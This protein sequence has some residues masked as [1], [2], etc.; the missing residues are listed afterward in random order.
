MQGL[1]REGLFQNLWSLS[2]YPTIPTGYTLRAFCKN[3]C[4]FERRNHVLSAASRKSLGPR[5][6]PGGAVRGP[7]RPR[8]SEGQPAGSGW[9]EFR[10][11]RREALGRVRDVSASKRRMWLRLES[12][13]PNGNYFCKMLYDVNGLDLPNDLGALRLL[14]WHC[15]PGSILLPRRRSSRKRCRADA[16]RRTGFSARPPSSGGGR[17]KGGRARRGRQLLPAACWSFI[18]LRRLS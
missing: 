5:L 8:M 18:F 11:Q 3:K 7:R 4:P 6:T 2:G 15:H 14:S 17:G 9:P 10:G 13:S 12:R 16:D 1:R